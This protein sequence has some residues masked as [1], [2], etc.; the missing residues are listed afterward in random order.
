MTPY[1]TIEVGPRA[2]DYLRKCLANGRQLAKLLSERSELVNGRFK[3][4]LPLDAKLDSSSNFEWAIAPEAPPEEQVTFTGQGGT[5]WRAVPKPDMWQALIDEIDAFL[6][7]GG[8]RLCVFEDIAAERG[9]RFLERIATRVAYGHDGTV[10]HL[11]VTTDGG[12]ENVG[13]TLLNASDWLTIGCMSTI[14]ALPPDR[15]QLSDEA[16]A[17]LAGTA[18][19]IV[20]TAFDGDGW[21]VWSAP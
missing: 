20:I 7:L 16:I 12:T 5:E 14:G 2:L 1:Q 13:A 6:S 18:E 17:S 15:E 3:V 9:D 21:L 10:F 8:D 19:Q 4:L 11:L